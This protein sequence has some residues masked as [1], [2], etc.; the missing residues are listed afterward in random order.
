MKKP[1]SLLLAILLISFAAN[2][3][4]YYFA[5]NGNDANSGTSTSSPWKTLNKFNSIF[6]SL[7]PGDYVLFNRGDV[8][9]GN[10][11]ISKSGS[12]GS[13]ITIGAYGSGAQPVITGFTNVTAWTNLGNNIW[14]S[15]SAI[16]TLPATDMVT[17][18]RK[19]TPMGRY[20]NTG[21]L[22]YQSFNGKTSITSS[23]VNS[24]ITN[25]TGAEVVIRKQR[26][27]IDRNKITGHSGGTITYIS[28]SNY[29][30]QTGYGFFIQNDARTLDTQ[31][32]WYYNP[33]TK[34]IRIYSTSMPSNVQVAT[35]DTLVY[36]K[37]RNY[38][39]FDNL[40][41]QGSNKDAFVILSSANVTIQNCNID[42]SGKDAIWGSQNFGLPSAN[43]IFK[44]ST[45]NHTNN[46]A[47]SLASEFAGALISHNSVK[48]TGMIV[49]MGQSGDGMYYGIQTRANNVVIENNEVDSVGYVGIGFWNNNTIV[50]NN[51]VNG[52]CFVKLDGAGI[53]TW[54]GTGNSPY[55]GQKVLNNIVL[56]GFG[57]NA[58]TPATGNP[59]S[60]GIYL[61]DWSANIEVAGNTISN[62]PH[63]GIYVHKAH[64]CNIHD[65]T[66]YNNGLFQL[67]CVSSDLGS[68]IR[69]DIIK[70]NIF[71]SRTTSQIVAGY[72]SIL[73]D[74]LSFG[75]IDYN[76]YARPIDDNIVFNVTLNNYAT[77]LNYNL[78]QWQA[79]SGFDKSSKKSPK[80]ISTVNDLRFEYNASSSSKTI[81]LDGTY[82]DVRNVSYNGSITLAPYTS[83]VL[84]RTGT[85]TN[86]APTANAGSNQT[87]TLP[88]STV[89]LS[90][91]GTDPD[92]SISAYNWTKTSG[93]SSGTISSPTSASTTVAGL[94]QGT[95][96]FQLKVTDNAGASGTATVQ[97]TV[98]PSGNIAPTAYAGNDQTIILPTSSVNLSGSGKD[99]DGSISSYN[100]TK[101]SGPSSGTI[102]SAGSASTSV[103][104]L[105]QGTYQF[106]LKVTDNNG[107]TAL[108]NVQVNV[109]AE[110]LTSNLL[111]AVNPSNTV[112]GLNYDY[113]E[114]K[115]GYSVLPNFSSL[116]PVK[117]GST[118]NFNISLANRSTAYSFNFTGYIDVPVDGQYVFYTTS[119]DG[120]KLYIDNVLVVNNDGLHGS[121]ENAGMIG[122]KAGK[123]A[124]SVGYFQQGG[125][126]VLNVSYNGPTFSKM[127]IPASSLYRVSTSGLLPAVNPAN[128][129]NG[130]DYKYYE[131]GSGWSVLPAFSSLPVSK[132]GTSSGFDISSASSSTT[133][134]Y[135]FTGY[136]NVP[137]D[138]Q[139][140]FY[141][142]SDDGSKLYIDNVLVV[143]ND[144]LH[145]AREAAG[146]IG[147]QK[148][149]H[150]ISV[151]Y[152]QQGGG[153]ILSVSYNGPGVSKQVI[154][155]SILYRVSAL[156]S[157]SMIS[158]NTSAA[159][160]PLISSTQVSV[161][162]YPNPF[163]NYID[164]NITGG[165]AGE[166]KLMLVDAAGKVVWTK[167]GTKNAG[168]FKQSIN[169]SNLVRGIYFL[170]VIQDNTNSVIKLVK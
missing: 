98:N 42:Y 70:N 64:D 37:Y 108:D 77:F 31:N 138:G 60:H 106:Q 21:Y 155:A 72:Q 83:A 130:L 74:I 63:S 170:K 33:S 88:T 149:K 17:I 91:S 40:S 50:R 131:S 148:G 69:N 154:P 97:I 113:Y 122:L 22:T 165:V 56:N 111:P 51:L 24:S 152:F 160:K 75:T 146:I 12:S 30:G 140:V 54:I 142:T 128:T 167:S 145:G 119:D 26:W 90:G 48:N 80:T 150:A 18:N 163:I 57:D 36:M 53:Y 82:I 87:I 153:S 78:S 6:S 45:I 79:Y 127:L 14:E 38:I 147:L 76:Y 161:K 117:S 3:R 105:V 92:G 107:A 96:Q 126:S 94:V 103:T 44:N 34:R 166:Y 139:Y 2:A 73:D 11:V 121:K 86:Q 67:L 157:T 52:F 32:E 10:L 41:I 13:P 120:S 62:C 156:S 89:T 7:S 104:G 102:S 68:L 59:I 55:T 151:G 132:T 46:N 65:N 47:I 114:S 4:T 16:S 81:T 71:F 61:D 49:G 162:G 35:K 23:S 66:S 137:A 28:S 125:G 112:N 19:N 141:T 39:T 25:W 5:A 9:Y 124:I 116:T 109:N 58:G 118:S 158:A 8:F 115:E 143:N 85:A 135:N 27:I 134:A 169:T 29:N 84:I 95:Y 100:W 129:V 136:V 15:S 93:P 159:N 1:L 133:F 168:V 20:P 164:V 144:G 110:S 123:H 43:F 99:T 101:T